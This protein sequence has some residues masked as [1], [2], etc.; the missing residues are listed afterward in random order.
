MMADSTGRLLLLVPTNSYRVSDFLDAAQRLGVAVAVGSNRRQALE[1]LSDGQT[2]TI[3]FKN[4]KSGLRQILDYHQTRPLQGIVA[5]DEVSGVLAATAAKQLGLPHNEPDAIARTGNK[6]RLRECLAGAGLRQPQFELLSIADGASLAAKGRDYPCVL[7]PLNMAASRGVIRADDRDSFERAFDRVANIVGAPDKNILV[8]DFWPGDEVAVEGLLSHGEFQCLAI[9]DKPDP[10]DGPY[11]EETVY[12]TPSRL[13]HDVQAAIIAETASAVSALGLGEGPVH[14]E[15]RIN[16]TGPWV[17]E[18]AARSIGGLCSRVLEFGAGVRL[19]DIILRHALGQEIGGLSR[20]R[21]AAG[22]MMIPIP[23]GGRL[24]AVG[25][26]KA[27]K[28]VS[29]IEEITITI[30]RG[31]DIVPLPEG[32]QYLGFIFAKSETPDGVETALRRAHELLEF[33]IR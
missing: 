25:G 6:F 12:V 26:L 14:A 4:S 19:E 16:Q 2:V 7:K 10:L 20:E 33:T 28:R 1:H 3:D 9:F 30:A 8:E 11:F 18:V 24:E 27:A 21:R 15:L 31:S 17:I 5:V 13:S 23:A 32:S 29:G 22:V